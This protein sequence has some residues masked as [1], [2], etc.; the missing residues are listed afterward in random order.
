MPLRSSSARRM[1]DEMVDVWL[2]YWM[3]PCT[4]A[5]LVNEYPTLSGTRSFLKLDEFMA[6]CVVLEIAPIDLLV[7]ATVADNE[8]YN[9]TPKISALAGNVR[10]WIAGEAPLWGSED[11][12]PDSPFVGVFPVYDVVR[13]MP[14]DRAERV[15]RRWLDRD[16]EGE[17]RP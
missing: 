12:G 14:K 5:R 7:P 6:L 11:L 15:T 13:W 1:F 17:P 3:S 9:V 16:D 8:S 2:L 10:E 4:L